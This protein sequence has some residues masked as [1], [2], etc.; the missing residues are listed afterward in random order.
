MVIDK[1]LI[2]LNPDHQLRDR[3]STII[4]SVAFFKCVSQSQEDE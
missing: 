2:E 4:M 1:C 3:I